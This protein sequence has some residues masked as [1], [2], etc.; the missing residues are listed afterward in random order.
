VIDPAVR[1]RLKEIIAEVAEEKEAVVSR[2]IM[3]P[4]SVD[5]MVEVNPQLGIH[6]LIK[7]IKS[8]S[9][10]ALRSEF[11]SLRS[12]LPSMWTNSYLVNTIGN[13]TPDQLI[14]QYISQQPKR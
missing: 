6:R 4:I 2:V 3:T 7:A 12:R 8:R 13:D 11:P 9:A 5:I 10:G 1:D 14:R